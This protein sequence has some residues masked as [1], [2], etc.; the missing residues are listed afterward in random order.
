MS[1][2]DINAAR[3][4]P[5]LVRNCLQQVRTLVTNLPISSADKIATLWHSMCQTA[6]TQLQSSI[7]SQVLSGI[8]A[9]LQNSIPT[10]EAFFIIVKGKLFEAMKFHNAEIRT[11]YF[12]KGCS[13]GPSGSVLD[14]SPIICACIEGNAYHELLPNIHTISSY[15][16][17]AQYICI[18]ENYDYNRRKRTNVKEVFHF[19]RYQ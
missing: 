11:I 10:P 2:N 3:N 15:Q 14:C 1:I 18:V 19:A 17:L 9:D 4:C 13:S 12:T 16:T 6:Y 8:G 5:R 7:N